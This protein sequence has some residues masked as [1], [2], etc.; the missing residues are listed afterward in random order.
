[1][2]D[3][4][5]DDTL[6]RDSESKSNPAEERSRYFKKL[7]E[8]LQE[9]Y[10][11]Q[12][13]AAMFPYYMMSGQSVTNPT[14]GTKESSMPFQPNQIPTPSNTQ[15]IIT[16]NVDRQNETVRQRRPQ[17]QPTGPFQPPGTDGY[18]YR[19]PPI[20][21]RFAAEF[22]DSTMLFLLKFSIT[23]IAIDV[24]DFIDI[25][26]LDLLQTNLRIDYKMALEMTYG[27]LI[28]EVIHRVIVCIF[29]A[30]WLQHGVYGLIGGA[31]PGK[32]MMGLRVVQCRSITPVERPNEQD[33]VLV[34]PGTDLGLP[35]ALGRSMVKNF[36]L[37]F[38]FPICFS[39]FF[40]RF[41]RTGYDL[42]CHSLVIEDP[43]RNN[44]RPHQ[45]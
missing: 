23:F 35:L 25:E 22:I 45:E 20:W 5:N 30:F 8:W 12:S 44:N 21:K 19:I 7:E 6:E 41:N 26:D 34:S 39:L 2:A 33:V 14:F 18:E 13:V 36:V 38:I 40:F 15:G 32:Y 27:I 4:K 29:E 28:L 9:A 17:E 37:A 3:D 10:A 24:F 16:G 31:T 43:Y 11:W 1:M 42:I